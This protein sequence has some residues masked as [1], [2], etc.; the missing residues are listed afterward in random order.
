MT[1]K[2]IN[3]SD[4]V[5]NYLLSVSLKEANI[6]QR[7]REETA[8]Q[9]YPDMQISP[10]QGQFMALLIKLLNV[11]KIIEIGVFTGYSSLCM[12]MAL[13]DDGKLIA[14]DINE[15]TSA[16]AKRYWKEAGVDRKIELRLAPATKTMD[17]LL[18]LG[19]SGTFDFIFI[20][21]HKPEYKD[22][23]ERAL[24]LL[25]Q[26]AVIAVDNVLWNGNPADP[27]EMDED[28][29]AIREFNEFVFNDTRVDISLLSI[30]DGLTLARKR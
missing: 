26:G 9:H 28:T 1:R 20:D 30:A 3:L 23:F 13:P 7:L 5:Y 8:S 10:D 12:A 16:I 25:R 17:S 19:E 21:A 24:K 27:K 2:S 18:D 4:E 15:E 14:C 6:L 29:I 22:Y 11:K